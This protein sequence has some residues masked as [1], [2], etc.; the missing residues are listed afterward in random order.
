MMAAPITNNPPNHILPSV[1]SPAPASILGQAFQSLEHLRHSF[2]V[3]ACPFS[4][5]HTNRHPRPP[6]LPQQAWTPALPSWEPSGPTE[7]WLSAQQLSGPDGLPVARHVVDSSLPEMRANPSQGRH[8]M[9]PVGEVR[10]SAHNGRT[11][12]YL[13]PELRSQG[14]LTKEMT[15]PLAHGMAFDHRRYRRLHADVGRLD[16]HTHQ[17]LPDGP[18][19]C[20]GPPMPATQ[21]G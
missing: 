4:T 7:E 15:Q 12:G 19:A 16:R 20:H 5:T 2:D 21:L 17:G 8:G 18:P 1:S 10:R 13:V 14:S 6:L 3:L 11:L 9:H